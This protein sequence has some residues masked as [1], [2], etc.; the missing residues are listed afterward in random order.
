MCVFAYLCS[1]LMW[2]IVCLLSVCDVII[3]M[4][5]G[6]TNKIKA[7]NI[8]IH[9]YC[10]GTFLRLK[11]YS[12]VQW[13]LSHPAPLHIW[14]PALN[15]AELE[16]CTI[17]CPYLYNVRAISASTPPF[18]YMVFNTCYS[19]LPYTI[20]LTPVTVPFLIKKT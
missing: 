1:I 18:L 14:F 7:R 16:P 17:L 15:S 12:M 9:I 4:S 19:T 6:N 8:N 2:K 13:A 11:R 5:G 10:I 20:N 3:V